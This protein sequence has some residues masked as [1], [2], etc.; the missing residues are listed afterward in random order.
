M[1]RRALL[2]ILAAVPFVGRLWPREKKITYRFGPYE[3]PSPYNWRVI[4][5]ELHTERGAFDWR[6]GEW[7]KRR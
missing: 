1:T 2:S 6:D 5:G 7:V 4:G 3:M